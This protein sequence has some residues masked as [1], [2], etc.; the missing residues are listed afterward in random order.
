MSEKA[1]RSW[2]QRLGKPLVIGGVAGFVGAYGLLTMLDGSLVGGLEPSRE[3]ALMVA[4][5][6]LLT[7]AGVLV[8]VIRPSLGGQFLDVEDA[9]E[10]REQRAMIGYSGAGMMALAGALAVAALAGSGGPIPSLIAV[11]A[12]TTLIGLACVTTAYQVRHMDELMLDVSRRSTGAAFYLLFIIG[13][14]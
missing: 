14:G 10:L 9:D 13:G 1:Q 5:I 8:G 7:G 6:Y 2:W 4:L 12:F 3:I 11:L